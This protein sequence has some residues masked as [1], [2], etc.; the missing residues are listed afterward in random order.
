MSILPHLALSCYLSLAE[1]L[2]SLS[3]QD[4]ATKWYDYWAMDHPPDRL[5]LKLLRSR[6]MQQP[7]IKSYQIFYAEAMSQIK[8]KWL[9]ILMKTNEIEDYLKSCSLRTGDLR[10]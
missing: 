7:E 4:G 2:K 8:G 10:V 3:L 1:D 6:I 5:S 9:I